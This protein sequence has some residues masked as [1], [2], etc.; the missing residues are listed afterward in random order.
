M[1]SDLLFAHTPRLLNL[2]THPPSPVNRFPSFLFV[3]LVHF[4]HR[5]SG[6]LTN[7]LT[8]SCVCA[9]SVSL[10]KVLNNNSSDYLAQ[11][12]MSHQSHYTKST[13]NLYVPRPRLAF[14]FIIAYTLLER[15]SG[16]S[17][18]RTKSGIS[19]LCFKRHLNKYMPE[20]NLSSNLDRFV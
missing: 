4:Q 12:F 11:L 8:D 15:P 2:T 1:R 19:L 17:C 5:H 13:N 6:V 16:T 7:T 20:N 18:L 10:R 14:F 3:F 9:L